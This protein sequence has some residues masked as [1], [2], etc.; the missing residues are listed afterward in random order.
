MK[1][2]SILLIL[3]LTVLSVSAQNVN[4]SGKVTDSSG[5]PLPGVFVQQ[6][7][8]SNTVSTDPTV[9]YRALVPYTAH[10]TPRIIFRSLKMLYI[11]A[12]EIQK[13]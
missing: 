11:F 5:E 3:L 2:I 6:S 7:G 13:V 1:R 8:T 4:V 10:F 9:M 12:S